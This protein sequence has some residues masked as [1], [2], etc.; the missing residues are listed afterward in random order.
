MEFVNK[1]TYTNCLYIVY[2]IDNKLASKQF[3]HL[4][5]INNYF[6][7]VK[8]LMIY[9]ETLLV[10]LPMSILYVDKGVTAASH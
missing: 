1:Y 5:T 9:Y 2:T 7:K 4:F 8:F 3:I 10:L 6:N